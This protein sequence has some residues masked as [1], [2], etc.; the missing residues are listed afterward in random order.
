ME[1][2]LY[3]D[4]E[5]AVLE[6]GEESKWFMV[7][8]GVEQGD[9]MSGFI[10]LLVVDSI[11]RKTTDGNN[12]RIRWKFTTKLEDLDFTDDIAR[13]SSSWDLVRVCKLAVRAC[14]PCLCERDS[15]AGN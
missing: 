5:C 7:K 11:M 1:Q 10:F 15:R 8:T 12:T 2:I 4:S 14:R 3:E 13:L 6:E 9:V